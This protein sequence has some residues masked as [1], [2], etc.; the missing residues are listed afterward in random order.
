MNDRHGSYNKNIDF[1]V[2][3]PHVQS[4]PA[5]KGYKN[6][7]NPIPLPRSSF[8]QNIRIRALEAKV[9]ALM[10]KVAGLEVDN[11]DMAAMIAT[12]SSPPEEETYPSRF[13]PPPSPIQNERLSIKL[14]A[15]KIISPPGQVDHPNR[16]LTSILDPKDTATLD[17]SKS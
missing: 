16:P 9:D 13:Y 10:K 12:L 4:L 15:R 3:V 1:E 8:D 11:N 5:Y 2:L 7:L 6:L 17:G 14:P